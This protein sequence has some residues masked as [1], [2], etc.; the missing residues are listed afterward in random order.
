MQERAL[1]H[2]ISMA[3]IEEIKTNFLE[4]KS[5]PVREAASEEPSLQSSS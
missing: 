4:G 5:L 2:H 1:F 3:F